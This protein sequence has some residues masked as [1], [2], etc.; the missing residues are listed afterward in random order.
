MNQATSFD[1]FRSVI[2]ALLYYQ[3]LSIFLNRDNIFY[4]EKDVF[5]K[6]TNV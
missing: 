3:F 4:T 6:Y 1:I 2:L 5:I